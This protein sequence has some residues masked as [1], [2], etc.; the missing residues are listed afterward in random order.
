MIKPDKLDPGTTIKNL[1]YIDIPGN[2]SRDY[3]VTFH[4]HK[5]GITQFKVIF[6]QKKYQTVP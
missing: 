4:A 1:D 2:A 6:E 5:D 3:K